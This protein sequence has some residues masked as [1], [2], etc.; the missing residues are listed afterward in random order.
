MNN[1][2]VKKLRKLAN[3]QF[4]TSLNQNVEILMKEPF[5]LRLKFAFCIVLKINGDSTTFKRRVRANVKAEL[6]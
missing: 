1:K 6:K 5:W 4:R 2:L 3:Y